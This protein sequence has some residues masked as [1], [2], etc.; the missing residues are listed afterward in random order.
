VVTIE[1]A[2]TYRGQC[3]QICG[4]EH[5]FMPI[6]VVAKP[7]AEYDAWVKEAKAKMPPPPAAP[8]QEAPAAG[9]ASAT[10]V[11]AADPNRNGRWT[12]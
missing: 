8:A 12:S 5:G 2:G 7:Q 9:A 3:S 11:A 4:K 1:K 6:V 10:Q